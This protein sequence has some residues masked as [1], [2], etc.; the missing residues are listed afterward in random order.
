MLD[1]GDE[2]R[3]SRERQLDQNGQVGRPGIEPGTYGLKARS[4][5]SPAYL[6]AQMS[7]GIASGS[8]R[9]A[10][11][12]GMSLAAHWQGRGSRF[13]PA[14]KTPGLAASLRTVSGPESVPSRSGG[15]SWQSRRVR[16]RGVR[17]RR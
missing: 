5:D 4:S 2:K 7:G 12:P 9:N 11:F 15:E 14:E 6:P 3:H 1:L 8:P 17:S 13:G 16:P 10:R